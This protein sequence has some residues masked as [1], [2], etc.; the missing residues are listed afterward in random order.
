MINEISWGRSIKLDKFNRSARKTTQINIWYLSVWQKA[1]DGIQKRHVNTHVLLCFVFKKHSCIIPHL[2]NIMYK[3]NLLEANINDMASSQHHQVYLCYC[4]V[5]NIFSVLADS[6]EIIPQCVC[7][8]WFRWQTLWTL[9]RVSQS[10]T[11]QHLL[12]MF[13]W[14]LWSTNSLFLD[15]TVLNHSFESAKHLAIYGPNHDRLVS[16]IR[17]QKLQRLNKPALLSILQ[18]WI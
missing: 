8:L 12:T 13:C 3:R 5:F 6:K 17:A 1:F 4:S 15:K 9:Q 16:S 18:S 7:C 2:P 10:Q 11:L 14:W